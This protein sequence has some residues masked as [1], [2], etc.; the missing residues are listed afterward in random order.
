MTT[1]EFDENNDLEQLD[2]NE[3]IQVMY[4]LKREIELGKAELATLQRRYEYLSKHIVPARMEDA[5]IEQMTVSGIGRVNLRA[6]LYASIVADNKESAFEWLRDNGR[7][8]L[9]T[10]TV[11]ASSLKASIR[12]AIRSGEEFPEDLF[13]VT[14]YTLAVITKN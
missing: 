8:S 13:K 11:N 3:S 14:P 6:D 9:I 4:K 10:E 12:A 5:G 7:E 2:L 1:E